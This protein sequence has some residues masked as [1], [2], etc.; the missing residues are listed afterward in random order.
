MSELGP[1]EQEPDFD[2]AA[3]DA[4]RGLLADARA[5]EPLPPD[6]A[7]RLDATLAGL[8]AARVA[9][10][11]EAVN[12]VVPLRRKPLAPR[13]LGAA[14]AIVLVGG[15]GV[16]LSQI[17]TNGGDADSKSATASDAGASREE[18][19][20][21]AS[22]GVP[23]TAA[24]SGGNPAAPQELNQFTSTPARFTAAGFDEQ[25]AAYARTTTRLYDL[26]HGYADPPPTSAGKDGAKNDARA[27]QKQ[28]QDGITSLLADVAA[29]A[30]CAGPEVDDE[31]VVVRILFDKSPATLVLRPQTKGG[32][33]VE[34][35]SCDGATRLASTTVDP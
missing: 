16:G 12:T 30:S 6:V 33:V 8:V 24:G 15:I 13:L 23:E 1:G 27:T 3:H 7:A 10:E 17:S 29:N 9:E 22:D 34:A 25:A 14:A 32:Q 31:S 11:V 18:A 2:D 26:S 21:A 20:G 35:W 28:R 5:D 19:P 4:L